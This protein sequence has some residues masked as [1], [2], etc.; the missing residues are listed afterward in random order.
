MTSAAVLEVTGLSK[1]FPGVRAL[2]DISF[3]VRPGEVH[4]LVGQNGAGKSTLIKVLV[5]RYQPDE[6]VVR[7]GGQERSGSSIGEARDSRIAVIHQDLNLVPTMSVAENIHLGSSRGRLGVFVDWGGQRRA[8]SA[9]FETI[10]VDIDPDVPVQELPLATQQMVAVARALQLDPQVMIMDEPTAALG[11]VEA[12]KV[13]ELVRL[14]RSQGRSVVYV[15]HRLEEVLDLSDRITVLRDGQLVGTYDIQDVPSQG[16][17]VEMI[18]GRSSRELVRAEPVEA[19]KILLRAENLSFGRV[20][21]DASI[22]LRAGEVVGL[23]GLVGSGRTELARLLFGAEK[24]DS[25][26]IYRDEKA[27]GASN[28]RDAVKAG[29]ALLPEDRRG[30]AA[31]MN[32][33]LRENLTLASLGKF[34]SSGFMRRGRERTA[35]RAAESALRIKAPGPETRISNLSGGN[36]QKVVIGKWL[37][38]DAAVMIFD[39]PTQGID[40]GAQEEIH[41]LMR[42]LAGEGRAILFISSDLGETVRVSDRIVVMREGRLVAELSHQE[43]DLEVVLQHC[44]GTTELPQGLHGGVAT[45]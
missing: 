35:Y 21:R 30:Q 25:G 16:R 12:E 2:S 41:A 9:L 38:T 15:S 20:V 29:V 34:S 3:D 26:T 42:R 27:L 37:E 32:M 36:Q 40:V 28:P 11:A 8:A 13:F 31:V 10:G 44:F 18:V 14:L 45:L 1:S 39:E 17:L 19:G 43:A 4:A 33:S 24:P 5:G 7:V 6:G 22:E 23:A